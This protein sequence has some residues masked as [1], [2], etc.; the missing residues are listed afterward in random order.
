MKP[1]EKAPNPCLFIEGLGTIGLPLS[2]RDA[3]AIIS[4]ATRAPFGRGDKTVVD[5]AVRHTWEIPPSKIG[6]S[7]LKWK[8]FEEEM[9]KEVCAGLGVSPTSSMPRAE[10]YKM[11]LY[12][13]GSQYVDY[14]R[15]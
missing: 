13:T 10:L 12:D 6:F 15:I 11:L 9:L 1:V 7:N 14:M 8:A 2:E 4:L 3:Q 5:P